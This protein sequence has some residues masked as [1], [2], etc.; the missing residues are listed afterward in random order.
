MIQGIP[1]LVC[2]KEK[3]DTLHAVATERGQLYLLV[4][5]V[6]SGGSGAR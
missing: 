2:P 5:E 3:G 1:L 6:A 4:G